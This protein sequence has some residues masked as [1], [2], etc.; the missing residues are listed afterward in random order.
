MQRRRPPLAFSHRFGGFNSTTSHVCAKRLRPFIVS[1]AVRGGFHPLA[2]STS[3]ANP[4][5]TTFPYPI[6]PPSA[7]GLPAA[8]AKEGCDAASRPADLVDDDDVGMIE[9][10]RRLCLPLPPLGH[11]SIRL[12]HLEHD[13]ARQPLIMHPVNISHPPNAISDRI[14]C[15]PTQSPI[16]QRLAR[17]RLHDHDCMSQNPASTKCTETSLFF[18]HRTFCIV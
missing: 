5:A 15:G 9:R 7:R 1:D 8:A 12:E 14:L 3:F 11:P 2:G 16:R 6:R 18:V 10:G 4:K 17:W 13:I